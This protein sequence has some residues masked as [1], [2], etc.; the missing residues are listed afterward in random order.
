MEGIR[1]ALVL[2]LVFIADTAIEKAFLRSPTL[3]IFHTITGC[4]NV[5][6]FVGRGK[7]TASE[8]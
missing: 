5:S 7:N 8:I 1:R 2:G 6:Y 4:D 3:P